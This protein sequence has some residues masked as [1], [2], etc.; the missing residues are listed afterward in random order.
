MVR[1][2]V[3]IVNRLTAGKKES[4]RENELLSDNLPLRRRFWAWYQ[5]VT[6]RRIVYQRSKRGKYK[7]RKIKKS[8][9]KSKQKTQIGSKVPNGPIID[10]AQSHASD[11]Q[12]P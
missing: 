8:K 11:T 6:R 9:Q 1:R 12:D 4:R 10:Y 2:D 7:N 3:Q 5:G